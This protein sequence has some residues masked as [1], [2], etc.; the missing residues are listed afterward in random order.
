MLS[1]IQPIVFPSKTAELTV[2]DLPGVETDWPDGFSVEQLCGC[3][4]LYQQPPPWES[5]QFVVRSSQDF[6]YLHLR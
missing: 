5:T 2:N 3:R 6:L 4:I 1:K